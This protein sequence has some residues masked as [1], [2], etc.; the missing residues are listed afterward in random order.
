V[1]TN[2][3][4]ILVAAVIASRLPFIWFGYGSDADAWR[5]AR[6]ARQLWNSGEYEPSRLPGYPLHEFLTTPLVAAGGAPLTNASSLAACILLLVV[7]KQLTEREATHP[8]LL[9]I[10][11]AFAPFVWKS[12][13]TT[14]DYI[15]SLLAI[16]LAL[17]HTMKGHALTSGFW[18][19]IAAGFR[20]TNLTIIVPL[21]IFMIIKNGSSKEVSKYATAA[22]FTALLTF[23][24]P[25]FK[26]GFAGWVASTQESTV[27]LAFSFAD[28]ALYFGYRLATFLGIPA[29]LAA[30]VIISGKRSSLWTYIR[31]KDPIVWCSLTGIFVIGV[32]YWAYPLERE[33]LL[34]MLPFALL[35]L[36]RIASKPGLLVFSLSFMSLSLLN[37]DVIRHHGIKGTPGFNLHEGVIIEDLQKRRSLLEL[38]DQVAALDLDEKSVVMTGGDQELWVENPGLRVDTSAFWK[39]F[40]ETAV[41]QTRNSDVHFIQLLTR[42]E[43]ERVRSAG[44]S[45]YYSEQNKEYVEMI[46]GYSMSEMGVRPVLGAPGDTPDL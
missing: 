43:L 15:W 16:V 27:D 1:P 32:Q 44:F 21:A 14:M 11:L 46:C 41:H 42:E 45:V 9:I 31:S 7:W 4:A 5:V 24:P 3:F 29:T 34:P 20:P 19:G 25:L 10:S 26:Y 40:G 8:S 23:L 2:H 28:R 33:Y 36:D 39:S 12:S 22:L 18:V 6:S 30:L 13:S 38:R 35:I 37:A 17:N